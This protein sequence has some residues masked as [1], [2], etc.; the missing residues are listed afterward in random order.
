[1]KKIFVLMLVLVMTIVLGACGKDSISRTS[2]DSD[3]PLLELEK[4]RE[5]P[6]NKYT[7]AIVQPEV[8]TPY[9]A[10][11]YDETVG[12]FSVS[13]NNVTREQSEEYIELLKENGFKTVA[14][15]SENVASGVLL[16]KGNV[17]V[18]IAASENEFGI[19]IRLYGNNT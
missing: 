17:G 19:Y 16:Q 7:A 11:V 14:N 12:Y 2:M 1:M 18:S 4:I 15:K 10:T 6:E 5:W 9:M 8:G 3:L 13:L